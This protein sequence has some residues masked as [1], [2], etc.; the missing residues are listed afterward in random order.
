MKNQTIY[1]LLLFIIVSVT[2]GCQK[3]STIKIEQKDNQL[4]FN[5][6]D[7][8]E[9]KNSQYI[10]YDIAVSRN[11]CTAENCVY[12]EIVRDQA[13]FDNLQ[14]SLHSNTILYGSKPDVMKATTPPRPLSSGE[15]SV[16]ASVGIV[17][18]AEF[19]QSLKIFQ[20]F[21]LTISNNKDLHIE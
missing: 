3:F 8:G 12:W 18:N 17:E 20:N 13:Y 10:L 2:T 16:A 7:I 4:A 6:S 9:T 21:K 1:T 14:Y 15:Y 5:F 19:K 11:N